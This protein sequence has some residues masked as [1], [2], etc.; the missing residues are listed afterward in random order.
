MRARYYSP[1]LR[2]FINADIM[3]GNISNAITLNRYAYANGNPV[4][5]IDP[6]G[7]SAE[8]GE[9][10]VDSQKDDKWYNK[11]G[12]FILN[13][14]NWGVNKFKK[15]TADGDLDWFLDLTLSAEKDENGIYHISQDYWQS[16]SLVGYN[17]FYDFCFE[18]GVGATGGTIDYVKFPFTLEDGTEYIIWAWKGD[19]IN[20]GS[21]AE[22]GIYKESMIPGH[23]LTSTESAMSMSLSLIEIDSGAI[24]YDYHPQEKQ[25][26]ITGFDP[27]HQNAMA[28]NLHVIA[29][30]DFSE[31]PELYEGFYNKYGD[32]LDSPWKFDG[33]VATLEW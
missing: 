32:N 24:L 9:S 31:N 23:W 21:G 29:T 5:N 6:F 20:L 33:K 7:L 30:I 15:W 22:V 25:W 10:R 13:I 2:R 8:R 19:Y 27:S 1:E 26:W 12:K 14:F 17:S 4:S 28:N 3:A 11:L 18:K 16:C